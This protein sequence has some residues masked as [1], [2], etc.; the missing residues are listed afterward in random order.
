M[1]PKIGL[2]LCSQL[3]LHSILRLLSAVH[4]TALMRCGDLLSFCET[5]FDNFGVAS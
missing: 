2:F 3:S 4:C 1:R 5:T